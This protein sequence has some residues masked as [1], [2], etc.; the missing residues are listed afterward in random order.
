MSV[1]FEGL[2]MIAEAEFANLGL[3]NCVDTI[4]YAA[5]CG[6][7]CDTYDEATELIQGIADI[8]ADS[9]EMEV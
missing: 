4:H 3:Y 9:N 5:E 6:L 8:A 1:T 7:I 2:V